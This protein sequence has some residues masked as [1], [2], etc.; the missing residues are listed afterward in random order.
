MPQISSKKAAENKTG[1]TETN[2]KKPYVKLASLASY[3]NTLSSPVKD[4]YVMLSDLLLILNQVSNGVL[5]VGDLAESA[6]FNESGN[7]DHTKVKW[8]KLTYQIAFQAPFRDQKYNNYFYKLP[9]VVVNPNQG[10]WYKKANDIRLKYWELHNNF[11]Y[12]A[13]FPI[14]IK[15]LCLN[16]EQEVFNGTFYSI[17]D[18]IT[19]MPISKKY[20]TR[21]DYAVFGMQ[22]PG[23]TFNS[24]ESR[25]GFNGM[26][27]DDEIAGNGN[28]YTAENW[29]YDAR[30]GIRWNVDPM[31][32]TTPWYSP[33]STFGDNPILNI[34]KEGKTKVTYLTIISNGEKTVIKVVD[35]NYTKTVAV[36]V[37]VVT[38]M[39]IMNNVEVRQYD[40]LET[41][42]INLDDPKKST[43]RTE[44]L[45]G[46]TDNLFV[47]TARK[48][49]SFLEGN[50]GGIVF[51]SVD[52]QGQET[53]IGKG[54]IGSA[55]NID[56]LIGVINAA[57]STA[58][59]NGLKLGGKKII[60]K[61]TNFLENVNGL[62]N[63]R[64]MGEHLGDALGT[65][66]KNSGDTI[67]SSCGTSGNHGFGFKTS[68]KTF[69]NEG[70][71]IKK[72]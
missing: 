59:M 8:A 56:D 13:Q 15:R 72:K 4:I 55:T 18:G 34:D 41:Q 54:D 50:G 12:A 40:V 20:T 68:G 28:T 17:T 11:V 3:Y 25:F 70:K 16:G 22:M 43:A 71:E 33:Y 45:L 63:A 19:P 42:T 27:K 21:G 64:E 57:N 51:T 53:R 32:H 62:L 49:G 67:C 47:K 31:A 37:P 39:G 30:T 48:V 26:E 52:G 61:I 7:F 2:V 10:E 23:R 58:S 36:T 60:E 14:D 9:L 65:G 5:V 6:G 66:E 35:K 38:Q 44:T 46:V 24:Q 69:N 29:E 1:A